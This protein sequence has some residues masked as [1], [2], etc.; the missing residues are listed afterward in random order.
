MDVGGELGE[1]S[2][3]LGAMIEAWINDGGEDRQKFQVYFGVELLACASGLSHDDGEG[4]CSGCLPVFLSG[5]LK[6]VGTFVG[7]FYISSSFTLDLFHSGP[8]L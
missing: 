1:W 6:Y 4:E 8:L 7:S 2:S 5:Q 3:D